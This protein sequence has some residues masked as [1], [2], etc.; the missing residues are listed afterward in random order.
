MCLFFLNLC[1]ELFARTSLH[2]VRYLGISTGWLSENWQ[3]W[4]EYELWLRQPWVSCLMSH[5]RDGPVR[6][7]RHERDG[8]SL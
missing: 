3:W 2:V 5:G 6:Q 8:A 4:P 1:P 7:R